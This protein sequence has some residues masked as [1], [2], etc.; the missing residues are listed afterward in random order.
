MTPVEPEPAPS[1]PSFEEWAHS[2]V[3]A[4][5]KRRLAAHA[6]VYVPI[7]TP[8]TSLG[9]RCERRI[10]YQR[11]G[12]LATPIDEGLASLFEEGNWTQTQVRAELWLLGM[13]VLETERNFKDARLEISGTVDGMLSIPGEG[14]RSRVALEIKRCMGHAP[15]TQAEWSQAQGL[16]SRYYAQ[17]T[18]YLFLSAMERGIGLFKD[19]ASGLWTVCPMRL[20]Y[21][22]AEV[23]VQR[24][25]R[26]RDAM[27]AGAT[28]DRIPDR[29]ECRGCPYRETVCHPADAEVDPLLVARDADLYAQLERREE[30]KAYRDEWEELDEKIK[31]RFRA[32]GGDRFVV[33]GASPFEVVKKR[34]GNGALRVRI[35]RIGGDR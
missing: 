8:A 9:Y 20:D 33:D 10:V 32:T 34:S 6:A 35:E 3:D 15:T 2:L 7:Y 14:H 5:R 1:G 21:E 26:V 17:V 25:E 11:Q 16:W 12:A 13:E 28:P 31:E 27:R 22:A 29:S 19:A 23:L 4:Q 18:I 30:L 24:A